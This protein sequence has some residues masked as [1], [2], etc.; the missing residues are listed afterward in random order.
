MT[1][2]D[3]TQNVIIPSE[4]F[5]SRQLNAQT[6]AFEFTSFG[7]PTRISA[8]QP[9]VLGAARLSAPRL[10]RTDETE[11]KPI[12][13][14]IVVGT[15]AKGQIPANLPEQLTYSG[16]GE[17]LTLSAGAWGYAFAHLASREAVLM[18]AP[19]LAKE[20]RLVS[21]YFIDHYLL[22]FILIDWAMLHASC[23]L[24]PDKRR[25]ILMIGPHNAGKSTTALQL[26]RAGYIFLADGMALLHPSQPG[27][28]VGGYPIGEVKLRDD[29]LAEFPE[30]TGQSVQVREDRKTVVD[31]RQIHPDRLVETC[32]HPDAICLCFVERGNNARTQIS[33]LPAGEARRQ[34]A[35]NTVFWDETSKLAKNS[36]ILQAL[37]RVARLYRLVI[38]RDVNNMISA[39]DTIV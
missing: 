24:S 5:W 36:A 25:L 19:E 14:Q 3:N 39:L 20:T 4:D 31:L 9:D 17:W 8:N 28:M 30:Y 1:E 23:V 35:A 26:L 16:V 10:S 15:E 22:N 38:G 27:F 13:I 29:V 11:A 33:S 32:V 12:S 37:I 18:L 34:L 21:R 2:H 7:V 6:A